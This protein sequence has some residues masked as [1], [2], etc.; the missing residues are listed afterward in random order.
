MAGRAARSGRP[1]LQ[2]VDQTLAHFAVAEAAR[3]D[4]DRA[5]RRLPSE[6]S[7]FGSG[8]TEN[9]QS[10]TSNR[11]AGIAAELAELVAEQVALWQSRRSRHVVRTNRGST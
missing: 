9:A 2:G 6:L 10:P 4:A 3:E 5:P 7:D 1:S 8:R 11:S